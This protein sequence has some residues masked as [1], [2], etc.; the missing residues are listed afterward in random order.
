VEKICFDLQLGSERDWDFKATVVADVADVAAVIVAAMHLN[1][2]F[3][4]KNL[5]QKRKRL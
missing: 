1:S 3:G 5:R 4:K 2:F